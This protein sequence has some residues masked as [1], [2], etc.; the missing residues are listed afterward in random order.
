MENGYIAQCLQPAFDLEAFGGLDVLQVN[1]TV[2]AG[3]GAYRVDKG[4][5]VRGVNQHVNGIDIGKALEQQGL[6]LHHRFAGEGTQ[7][8]QSQH[9]AAIGNDRNAVALAG[10]AIGHQRV[11]GDL[12]AGLCHTRRVGHRQMPHGVRRLGQFDA[13][14]PRHRQGVVIKGIF[15]KL[16]GHGISALVELGVAGRLLNKKN[17]GSAGAC[18]PEG[19][20]FFR[21]LP[22]KRLLKRSTRPPVSTIFCL[23]VKK[24]WHWLQTSNRMSSHTVERVLISLPQ[25]Q[26]AVISS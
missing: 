21:L 23:P 7:I 16:F 5:D 10:I 18:S 12:A 4:I 8:A 2:G 11:T 19:S 13:D 3:D 1:A 25:L 15:Q 22:P 17:A 9:G 14:L 24:G 20:Y 26:R 6:T